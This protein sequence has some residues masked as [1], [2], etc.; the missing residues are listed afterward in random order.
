MR[1]CCII[2]GQESVRDCHSS[3]DTLDHVVLAF[4]VVA[5][6]TKEHNIAFG[7]GHRHDKWQGR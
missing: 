1:C 3:A 5:R 7:V 6:S 4:A 2:V